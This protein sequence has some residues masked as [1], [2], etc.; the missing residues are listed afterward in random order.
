M[1]VE[2]MDDREPPV[3]SGDRAYTY[4]VTFIS[5][6]IGIVLATVIGLLLLALRQPLA[7]TDKGSVIWS[8]G[9][10]MVPLAGLVSTLILGWSVFY[11]PLV[12]ARR[13]NVVLDPN[14]WPMTG[15]I[16]IC[17]VVVVV[18]AAAIVFGFI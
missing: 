8:L 6:G 12:L 7:T 14:V 13:Q 15:A 11:L 10:F 18:F 3:Y 16:G 9:M 5:L 1:R 2:A 4:R 17:V